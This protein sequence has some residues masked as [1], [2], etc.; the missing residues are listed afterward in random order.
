[1]GLGPGG[2]GEGLI[3]LLGCYLTMEM[4]SVVSGQSASIHSFFILPHM[5]SPTAP[6]TAGNTEA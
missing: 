5:P 2:L 3:L 6:L 4:F 1:M